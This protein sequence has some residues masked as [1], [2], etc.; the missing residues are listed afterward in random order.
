MHRRSVALPCSELY[1]FAGNEIGKLAGN[2][3]ITVGIRAAK[4]NSVLCKLQCDMTFQRNRRSAVGS[5]RKEQS[6]AGRQT[7]DRSLYR[8]RIIGYT[9]A[10]C[11]EIP[12]ADSTDLFCSPEDKRCLP[13]D[14]QY[15]FAGR[16]QSEHGK[17]IRI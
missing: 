10:L 11:A 17:N 15:I 5:R 7:V 8:G 13:C 6:S 4:Q 9:V 3:R 14:F 12:D 16:A 2:D 1:G